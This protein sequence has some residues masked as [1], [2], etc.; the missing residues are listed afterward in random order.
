MKKEELVEQVTDYNL[1][2]ASLP[3]G[4]VIQPFG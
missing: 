2:N 1:F 4:R 3:M